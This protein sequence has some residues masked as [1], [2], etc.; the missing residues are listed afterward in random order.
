MSSDGGYYSCGSAAASISP[1]LVRAATPPTPPSS[2]SSG[3]TAHSAAVTVCASTAPTTPKKKKKFR[4]GREERRRRSFAARRLQAVVRGFLAR[5][6]DALRRALAPKSKST[7]RPKPKRRVKTMPFRCAKPG[8]RVM[9]HITAARRGGAP[10][11]CYKCFTDE[12]VSYGCAVCLSNTRVHKNTYGRM[13]S[14][15]PAQLPLICP[16][17]HRRSVPWNGHRWYIASA[18]LMQKAWRRCLA[19][20]AAQRRAALKLQAAARGNHARRCARGLRLLRLVAPVPPPAPVPMSAFSPTPAFFELLVEQ[21]VAAALEERV[22]AAL[23]EQQRV[24]Q[25]HWQ[26]AEQQQ[27]IDW[28]RWNEQQSR[29]RVIFEHQAAVERRRE[30]RLYHANFPNL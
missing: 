3:S 22:A 4:E 28:Q 1:P 20:K 11:L 6:R 8:C 2:E 24:Q 18:T 16:P 25:W 27:R 23:A 12:T 9:V 19:T 5:R 21:R 15:V 10:T 29:E 13:R 17:C 7:P 30:R 14:A 26:H